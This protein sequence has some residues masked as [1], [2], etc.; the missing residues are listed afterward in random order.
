MRDVTVFR[1]VNMIIKMGSKEVLLILACLCN[2][3]QRYFFLIADRIVVKHDRGGA[4]TK[5]SPQDIT[6]LRCF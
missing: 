1:R 6:D 5:P 2:T 3:S 4:L